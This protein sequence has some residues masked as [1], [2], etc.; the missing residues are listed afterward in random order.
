MVTASFLAAPAPR[1]FTIAAHRPFLADLAGG[2]LDALP[3]DALADAVVLLPSRRP[4]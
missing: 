3:Q 4:R 2:L 1:W